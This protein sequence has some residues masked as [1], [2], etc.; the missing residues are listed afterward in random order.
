[1][2]SALMLTD[3]RRRLSGSDRTKTSVPS[4]ASLAPTSDREHNGRVQLR[5]VAV[6][7]NVAARTSADQKLALVSGRRTSDLRVGL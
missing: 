1:M 3:Q 2:M 5:H 4:I 6:Q 7:G